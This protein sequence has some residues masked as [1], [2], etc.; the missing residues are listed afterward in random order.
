[1]TSLIDW[2]L[3]LFR[4]PDRAQAFVND[5]AQAMAD[6]GFS[7][8]SSAQLASVATTAVPS[9]A[10]GDGDPVAGLQQAVSAHYGFDSGVAPVWG[11]QP[12][13][14]P[15]SEPSSGLLSGNDTRIASPT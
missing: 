9:L 15:F 12:G 13:W 3:D 14:A 8:V 4:E 6:A 10:L 1:M 2:I 11:P 7:D 5:P